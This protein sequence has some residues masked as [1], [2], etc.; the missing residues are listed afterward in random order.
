VFVALS[1]PLV[2]RLRKAPLAGAFLD[3]VNVAALALMLSVTWELEDRR[4]WTCRPSRSPFLAR[5]ADPISVNSAWLILG[6]GMLGILLTLS[7]LTGYSGTIESER[8]FSD[9]HWL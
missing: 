9:A 1:G 3:G 7:G 5:S 8:C 6:A 2:P 4:S